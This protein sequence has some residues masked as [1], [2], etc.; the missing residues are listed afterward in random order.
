VPYSWAKGVELKGV[1]HKRG[2]PESSKSSSII[3]W[4]SLTQLLSENVQNCKFHLNVYSLT[5]LFWQ[6]DIKILNEKNWGMGRQRLFR[7]LCVMW[8][9]QL[10][11]QACL[12]VKEAPE[13]SHLQKYPCWFKIMSSY[14]NWNTRSTCNHF[15]TMDEV[16]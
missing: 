1:L 6:I 2:S 12:F 5:K 4:L 10:C 8:C 13:H 3:L 16:L 9:M 11:T 14:N 15:I 7:P